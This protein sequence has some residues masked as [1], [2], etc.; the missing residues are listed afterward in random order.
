MT[1]IKVV[2]YLRKDIRDPEG[3]EIT[4]ALVRLGFPV[5]SVAPG[6]ELIIDVDATDDDTAVELVDDMC[7]R[8]LL[9]PILH[10]YEISVVKPKGL[11]SMK[12][13]SCI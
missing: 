7:Q 8:M 9:N 12:F 11:N 13:N 3:V 1:K 6:R 2:Q 5:D 10:R 4:K